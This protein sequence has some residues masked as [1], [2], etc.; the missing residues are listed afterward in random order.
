MTGIQ[1]RLLLLH[2]TSDNLTRPP[3]EKTYYW[4]P[5][6]Y[7][8]FLFSISKRFWYN[9]HSVSSA[10]CGESIFKHL[11]QLAQFLFSDWHSRSKWRPE[12]LG[13][14]MS[15]SALQYFMTWP[16]WEHL[17]Q[18]AIRCFSSIKIDNRSRTILLSFLF[19]NLN[20]WGLT[21][22]KMFSFSLFR[23]SLLLTI[24]I[25]PFHLSKSNCSLLF[26]FL[27]WSTGWKQTQWQTN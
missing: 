14:T 11:R 6:E 15:F 22:T 17:W 3:R 9:G 23:H 12:H 18:T 16:N 13:H 25:P 20:T 1:A 8:T 10:E 5:S 27:S 19:I 26:F 2:E 7:L 21:C 4:L 24:L